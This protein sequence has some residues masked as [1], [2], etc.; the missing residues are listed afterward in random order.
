M[1]KIYLLLSVL[2]SIPLCIAGCDDSLTNSQVDQTIIPSSNV[3]YAKYIQPVLTVKC[4][5]SGCHDDITKASS[6]S[7]TSYAGVTASPVVVVKGSAQTSEL[8][9]AIKG[10]SG[11]NPMPPPPNL[12]PLTANQITGISTWINEGAK[13]N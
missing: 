1:K 6:L 5:S 10:Q 7:L 3:S 2:L 4:A 8:V 9:W 12:I 11:T 13:N